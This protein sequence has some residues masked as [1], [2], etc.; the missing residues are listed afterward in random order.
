MHVERVDLAPLGIVLPSDRVGVVLAQPYL[1]LTTAEPFKCLE[2]AKS[3][4]LGAIRETLE[5]ARLAAHGAEKTHFTLFP[6]YSIPGLEGVALIE[7]VMNSESWP[8]ATI[9]I[10]GI[11]ALTK[12]EYSSLAHAPHSHFDAVANAPHRVRDNEWVNCSVTWVKVSIG[13]QI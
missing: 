2:E 13:S 3:A 10:G 4:Q 11:D 1:H 9:V 5:V 8:S 7:E 6:E 12:L